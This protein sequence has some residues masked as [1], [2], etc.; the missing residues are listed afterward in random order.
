MRP[1]LAQHWPEYLIEGALLGAFMISAAMFTSLLEYPGSPVHQFIPNPHVRRA[2]IGLAMGLTA[3]ALIYSPWGQ[4]SGAHM[5]PATTLTF[6]RLGKVTPWDAAFYI[7]AQFVGGICGVL[8]SKLSLPDV[9]GHPS[10]H[11]VATVPGRACAGVAFFAEGV[12]A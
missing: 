12:I 3:I 5:N 9:I 8:L 10:V 6:L 2:L 1:M 7:A 11:Y 4:R